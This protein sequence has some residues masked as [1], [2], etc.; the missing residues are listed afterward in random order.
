MI[1]AVPWIVSAVALAGDEPSEDL[2][3]LLVDG[4]ARVR[5]AGPV[6]QSEL[7]GAWEVERALF[8]V[9]QGEPSTSDQT[10]LAGW[11]GFDF[12]SGGTYRVGL[13]TGTWR[14]EDDGRALVLVN[15]QRQ[16]ERYELAV[17]DGRMEWVV[18]TPAAHGDFALDVWVALVRPAP[19]PT[20]D[21]VR[22]EPTALRW[23]TAPRPGRIP[24]AVKRAHPGRTTCTVDLVV[25]PDGTLTTH[26][27]VDC[28]DAFRPLTSA[29]LAGWTAWPTRLDGPAVAEVA[30]VY[31]VSDR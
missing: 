13:G 26:A 8:R 4:M 29:A 23:K 17:T 28:P 1:A 10:A 20:A 2:G 3:A 11:G 21:A 22:V 15:A 16:T 27:F 18:S 14:L 12:R 6:A 19:D 25:A 9:H 30:F 24:K 7:L 5:A 31:V